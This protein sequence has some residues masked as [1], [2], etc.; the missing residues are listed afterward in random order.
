M[1]HQEQCEKMMPQEECYRPKAV[2]NWFADAIRQKAEGASLSTL[3]VVIGY[4]P[5]SIL[6]LLEDN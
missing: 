5:T 3:V 2:T 4:Q 1:L 6:D